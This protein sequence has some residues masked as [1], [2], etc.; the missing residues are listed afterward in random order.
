M[1]E[2]INLK[3]STTRNILYLVKKTEKLT[4]AVY[5]VTSFMND[6]EDLK[7]K[8]RDISTTVLNDL[9]S[10]LPDTLADSQNVLDR[11]AG[12]INGLISLFEV[13]RS[14]GTVSDMN[15]LV[16]KEEYQNIKKQLDILRG[17]DFD[18]QTL[19]QTE[20]VVFIDK[21]KTDLTPSLSSGSFYKGHIKDTKKDTF[22]KRHYV[23][24]I[25]TQKRATRPTVSSRNK[26]LPDSSTNNRGVLIVE[27]IKKNGSSSI[28]DIAA[29]IKDCSEKTIQ[30]ELSKLVSGGVLEKRGERRWSKYSMNR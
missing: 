13:A 14:T 23:G 30:R 10:H 5:K 6:R 2:D 9:A 28:K 7:W 25:P 24:Q 21:K 15:F 12:E 26:T 20:D 17:A 27:Y 29:V 11:I 18:M 19:T 8:I 16:L 1:T 3:D 4:C 22:D